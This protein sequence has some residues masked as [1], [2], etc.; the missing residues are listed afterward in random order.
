MNGG[1]KMAKRSAKQEQLIEVDLNGKLL[2]KT[3]IEVAIPELVLDVE[4]QQTDDQKFRLVGH[5]I[6]ADGDT[7]EDAIKA[8]KRKYKAG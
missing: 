2:G 6:V 5:D 8:F 1:E 4:I 3:D 7:L